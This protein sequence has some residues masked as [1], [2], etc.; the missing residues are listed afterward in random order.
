MLYC[1][2]DPRV[3]HVLRR[4]MASRVLPRA[5]IVDDVKDLSEIV[6]TVGGRP[7]HMLFA[8]FPCVGF[9]T[10]GL[11]AGLQQ[12][13]TALFFDTVKV[14]RALKPSMVLFENVAAITNA[15]NAADFRTA[16][17]AVMRAGY[18]VRWTT[19]SARS[20]GAPHVRERWFCLCTAKSGGVFPRLKV[21]STSARSPW[22]LRG[23][24]PLTA[25]PEGDWL[26]R[27]GMMGNAIVP[28]AA[29]L[30]FFRL[31]TGFS[32]RTLRD[33]SS[34]RAVGFSR[35]L[36]A[37]VGVT[38]SSGAAKHGDA[39]SLTSIRAIAVPETE[40]RKDWRI[41]LDP[42]HYVDTRSHRRVQQHVTPLVKGVLH[43]RVW[44]TVRVYTGT[45]HVLTD[46]MSNTVLTAARY[47]ASVGGVRQPR[48]DST[49][50]ANVEFL[51]WLMGFPRGH[52]RG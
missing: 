11:N 37:D 24:P 44:P 28:L 33:L 41:M 45:G 31:Y 5:P 51:E 35:T 48:T 43:R 10:A 20:V 6:K 8:S 29:R 18:E 9:S 17:G 39:S 3:T 27:V 47:A 23:M 49:T 7:V 21:P 15:G 32:I 13:G 26:A 36:S 34:A 16:I 52:T 25:V 12:E 38:R 19:C 30:A 1:D 2:N 14:I 40:R 4:L 50:R 22:S 46:R 42:D